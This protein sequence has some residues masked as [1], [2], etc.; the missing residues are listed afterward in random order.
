MNR[1]VL[2]IALVLALAALCASVSAEDK[3]LFNG[4]DL[5]GWK[6]LD[7]W[8]VKDGAITGQTTGGVTEDNNAL[9][10]ATGTLT[11]S[12]VD[13]G[14]ASLVGSTTQAGTYGNFTLNTTTG[15]WT[16]TLD[17]A[18]A[19]TQGLAAGQQALD[20]L[21]RLTREP[22]PGSRKVYIQGS[23]EGVQVPMREVSLTNGEVDTTTG[24]AEETRV[25]V[26]DAAA[27]RASRGSA[28][29][30]PTPSSVAPWN[31]LV[32]PSVRQL[33]RKLQTTVA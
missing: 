8:S 1:I 32:S 7:F 21:T 9:N 4:K 24:A 6:G 2:V 28:P 17:N 30:L 14:E 22:L 5:T 27:A 20:E 10:T 13:T 31:R 18:K 25:A 16:Y 15:V 3:N 19:A 29:S 23:H 26:R 12:D 11:V 33:A